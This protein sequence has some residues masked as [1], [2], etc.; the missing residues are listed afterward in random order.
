MNRSTS[1]SQDELC[2]LASSL[3]SGTA[4][5]DDATRLS[6]LLRQQPAMQQMYLDFIDTHAALCW[7]FRSCANVPDTRL[8]APGPAHRA[9]PASSFNPLPWAICLFALLITCG[10]WLR[11]VRE[12]SQP[13]PPH[14]FENRPADAQSLV[15]TTIG[16]LAQTSAVRWTGASL[17]IGDRLQA[18]PL[19]L[20]D[21]TAEFAFDNGISMV[22]TGPAEIE[23][24]DQMHAWLHAGQVVF[25]VPPTAIGFKVE[26]KDATIV[27]LGTEF[28]VRASAQS[29]G[30]GT[31]VQVYKG[32]VLAATRSDRAG[33]TPSINRLHGGQALQ[34]SADSQGGVQPLPFWPER[35]IHELPDPSE[36]PDASL[37]GGRKTSPYN[38]PQHNAIHIPQALNGITLD[39]HLEEW[40]LSGLIVSRCE[41]P[42]GEFYNLRGAMMF[43]DKHLYIGAIVADPFP[44]RSS[45]SPSLDRE[46]YGGGGCVALRISTDRQLAW[47][48]HARS[49]SSP[50]PRELQAEDRNDHLAFIVLWYYAAE[51]LPCLHL[52]YGM[53]YHGKLINPPGYRGAW[54]KH[55]DG[56]G[57]TMEY[58]IPWSLLNAADDPP[59]SGD[60][61]AAS[62]L[63]H[64]S[65]S[66]GRDWK[67]QLIDIVNT[68]EPGWNF[69]NAATW[70]RAVYGKPPDV[71][72]PDPQ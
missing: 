62:W 57:Y 23:L 61:L 54:K 49:S 1:D 25:R 7:E 29:P 34:V 71:R 24:R 40:D 31:E 22:L 42:W 37:E 30:P 67:G 6:Q 43:D 55:A 33:T 9:E 50:L 48:V 51:Q 69:Q 46:L 66:H 17:Q 39:G 56:L 20:A 11:P 44:M 4:T 27:D 26:T 68:G 47:P 19:K 41:P 8:S 63:V 14:V 15:R 28:G 65:D 18:G 3:A 35:F 72:S 64:W 13:L 5:P 59:R 53:D 12:S 36:H 52:R 16:R 60:T 2:R 38:K 21:G 70:G 58:A 45:I 32:E 10:V